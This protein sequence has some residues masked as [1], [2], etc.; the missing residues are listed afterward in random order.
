MALNTN[1]FW[2]VLNKTNVYIIVVVSLEHFNKVQ[3][4]K[5]CHF[6]FVPTSK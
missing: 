1:D 3:S 2:S 4:R 6:Q 5:M